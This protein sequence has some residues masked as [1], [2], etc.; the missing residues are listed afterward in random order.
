MVKVV[1]VLRA[2]GGVC[3]V[4]LAVSSD[5]AWGRGRRGHSTGRWSLVAEF[6][7]TVVV[8]ATTTNDTVPCIAMRQHRCSTT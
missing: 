1:L 6:I 7:V 5:V 3:H 8:H 2:I 4:W